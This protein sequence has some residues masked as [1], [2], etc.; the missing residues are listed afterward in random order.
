MKR[1]LLPLF[2][3]LTTV[4]NSQ[5]VNIPDANFKAALIAEGVDTNTD[6]EIQESEAVAATSLDISG[7]GISDLTGITSFV[8]L[9]YLYC[10]SNQLTSLN[11]LGLTA[12][13]DLDCSLNNLSSLDVSAFENLTYLNCSWN[14]LTS[15]NIRNCNSLFSLQCYNNQLTDLELIGVNN[16]V[17]VLA[18]G[19]NIVELDLSN[20]FFESSNHFNFDFSSNP[21]EYINI[22][23]GIF[24]YVTDIILSEATVQ[25]ICVDD[26][27]VLATLDFISSYFEFENAV[28][29]SYCTFTPGGS[30][31]SITGNTYFDTDSDGC[32]LNDIVPVN[33]GISINDGTE[34][35]ATYADNS[36]GYHFY[37]QSGNFELTPFIENPSWF[38][39]SPESATIEFTDNN[40]NTTTQDFCL[41]AVGVHNDVEII[42][43]PITP[44]QPGFDA[45]YQLVYRNKGNQTLSGEINFEYDDAVLD[46]ISASIAPDSQSVGVLTWNYAD[47]LPF[48][49]RAFRVTLNVNAPTETPAVNIGDELPFISA[50]NPTVGD[51]NPSDNEFQFKQTVV[52]S[53]DPNDKTCLEGD[54][55]EPNQIG[56]YLHFNINF[57]NTGTAAATFVVVKDVIDETMF[58]MNTLQVMYASHEMMTQVAGNK[59]EFIFDNI[60]L[61]PEEK[62]NV[63]FKIK[64]LDTL[65]VGDSVTNDAEIFFDYNFPIVTNETNTT[66]QTLSVE[67][68]QLGDAITVYPI[69][70]SRLLHIN[71][72]L[73][74][75]K[76]EI[77]DVQ[78]RLVVSQNTNQN[79]ETLN[80]SA[81]TK[82]VYFVKIKTKN[83]QQIVNI[84]KE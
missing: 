70:T 79:K 33:M 24:N 45:I 71:T 46:Y 38:D 12:L 15:L 7:E 67:E 65:N 16:L 4:V 77:Y 42:I 31:N 57:E 51:E 84:I 8:N 83:G 73:V 37:T 74:I 9:I 22:K 44:A 35:G 26:D 56:E 60:N 18:S 14:Q 55:V 78:G 29:S 3:I 80:T 50:I 68:N 39:I 66:F 59:I 10:Q 36:G 20:Y 76:V 17:N 11:L 41:T 69:P 64:T 48:E 32:D 13:E 62:G 27:E 63:V 47:L 81:L 6:G 21:I 54:I 5:I 30:Y 2:F 34:Q 19:N 23:N 52:G 53:Y 49:S 82:G 1:L 43:A 75:Q 58:D 40:N 28:V 61:G 25:Y 72:Q